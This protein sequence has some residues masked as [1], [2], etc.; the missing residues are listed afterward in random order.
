ML[1]FNQKKQCIG[2]TGLANIQAIPSS[3]NIFYSHLREFTSRL[4]VHFDSLSEGSKLHQ[5]TFNYQAVNQA[6]F[7]DTF[8]LPSTVQLTLSFTQNDIILSLST[9]THSTKYLDITL[10]INMANHSLP[11]IQASTKALRKISLRAISDKEAIGHTAK[12]ILN[13]LNNTLKPYVAKLQTTIPSQTYNEL[14]NQVLTD[15]S[16]ALNTS[17]SLLRTLASITQDMKEHND[18]C[19]P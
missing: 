18:V 9:T 14:A 10:P 2:D 6:P 16:D 4:T 12:S 13:H 5:L 3:I 11:D 19:D 8:S 15:I 7:T 17:V 1:L